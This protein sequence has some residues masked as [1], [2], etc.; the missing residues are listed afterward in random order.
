MYQE[1]YYVGSN[2]EQVG[3]LSIDQLGSVGLKPDTLVWTVGLENWKPAKDVEELKSLMSKAPPPFAQAVPLPTVSFSDTTSITTPVVIPEK[4]TDEYWE[5]Q[6]SAW[7]TKIY[8][9]EDEIERLKEQIQDAGDKMRDCNDEI[10]NNLRPRLS[11]AKEQVAICKHNQDV[12]E[13]P[14]EG[15]SWRQKAKDWQRD[16]NDIIRAMEQKSREAEKWDKVKESSRQSVEKNRNDL[17]NAKTMLKEAEALLQK[18][19]IQ[20]M[21]KHYQI[22]AGK[23]AIASTVD[24]FSELSEQFSEMEGYKDSGKLAYDALIKAKCKASG[25]DDFLN[26]AQ[27]FRKIDGYGNTVELAKE[28]ENMALKIRYDMLVNAKSKASGE[29]DFLKLAKQF[30]EMNGYENTG[31]LA[32]ECENNSQIIREKAY[33]EAVTELQQLNERIQQF[34]AKG[35]SSA[36]E[37]EKLGNSYRTLSNRF[38]AFGKYKDATNLAELCKKNSE[39]YKQKKDKRNQKDGCI[40]LI[41]IAVIVVLMIL[42]KS[43]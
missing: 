14:L 30:R 18:T 34:G 40:I 4:F 26:L 16:V 25:E 11:E 29:E 8:S 23:N 37:Y 22:L 43:C 10:R 17:K 15:L 12:V 36:S 27:L 20:R 5:D 28:C 13:G 7:E 6:K 3:P 1:F 24:E 31:E 41:V 33:N 35:K 32:I 38:D 39:D 2:N 9:L 21:E 19:P 42:A